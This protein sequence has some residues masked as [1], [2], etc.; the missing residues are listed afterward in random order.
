LN[1]EHTVGCSTLGEEPVE[2]G[3]HPHPGRR[4]ARRVDTLVGLL[5]TLLLVPARPTCAQVGVGA[6]AAAAQ[7]APPKDALG[8]DTPKRT[9]LGFITAARRGNDDVTPLYLDTN[10]KG[11]DAVDLAHKLYVVLDTRLPARL[12]E[13]SDLPEG[14]ADNVLRPNE[15]IVGTIAT[16]T[17][18]FDVVVER[19]TRRNEPPVWLFSRTT[20]SYVPDAFDELDR[21]VLDRYLPGY[22][23]RPRIAGIRLFEWIVLFGVLPVV[24]RLLG[25]LNWALGPVMR[26]WD[27]RPARAGRPPL[28]VPGLIRLVIIAIGIRWLLVDIDLPLLERQFWVATATLLLI[29]AFGWLLLLLSRYGERYVRTVWTASETASLIRLA[30]QA[31]DVVIVAAC[32]VATLRYFGFDPTA[33]LAGLGIGGIAIALAAQKTLE[34]VIAGLSLIFD[35]AV[36]VGD[37]LKF[38]DTVGTVDYIGLRSTRIRTLDRTILTVPNGLIASASVERI[39]ERDKYWFHHVLGLRYQTTPDQMRSV[40]DGVEKLLIVHANVDGGSVRVRFLRLGTS[41]LD[42]ELFAYVFAA[43]WDRFLIVQQEL[44]LQA[45]EIVEASG[46]AIAFPSQTLYIKDGRVPGSP[47]D[48][49]SAPRTS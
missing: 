42:I 3:N 38:G 4:V 18:S 1:A 29:V 7:P 32:S 37:S 41:S 47:P 44:L 12:Q 2:L 39:S 21:V 43:D 35:K 46:T 45:M 23:S 5:L 48:T 16:A 24:Y 40:I 15:N 33:A 34:N 25:L 26:L 28:R 49:A 22:V 17:G 31:V 8:R 10:L 30:R 11:K 20:L 14:S 13:L 27:R 36:G 6:P 19:I 9:V